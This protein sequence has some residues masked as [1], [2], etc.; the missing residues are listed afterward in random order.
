[1][2][3]SNVVRNAR[4]RQRRKADPPLY[5]T[6]MTAM[7]L[8]NDVLRACCRDA[9]YIALRQSEGWEGDVRFTT[10]ERDLA[11]ARDPQHDPDG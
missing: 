6:S 3:A 8:M 10:Q 5:R 4:R 11:V 2:L 1:L 7:I 9:H